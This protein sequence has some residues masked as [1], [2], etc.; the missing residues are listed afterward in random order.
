MLG[1]RVSI[2]FLALAMGSESLGETEIGGMLEKETFILDHFRFRRGQVDWLKKKI[3][4]EQTNLNSSTQLPLQLKFESTQRVFVQ[5]LEI[6]F[7]DGKKQVA[8]INE[9]VRFRDRMKWREIRVETS[10]AD[11]A[12]SKVRV[13]FLVDPGLVPFR[14]SKR[15]VV[16]EADLSVFR[17]IKNPALVLEIV[18]TRALSEVYGLNLW[19]FD[20]G[21]KI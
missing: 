19:P 20:T 11:F 13:Y 5:Y 18:K 10:R 21:E 7:L 14:S 12:G 16:L 2:F 4:E 1:M 6:E 9:L 17:N 8:P 3:K 15:Q